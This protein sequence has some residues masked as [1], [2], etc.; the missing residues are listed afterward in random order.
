MA[1]LGEVKLHRLK[2][3]GLLAA[4]VGIVVAI[5]AMAAF[6][7]LAQRLTDARGNEE[8]ELSAQRSVGLAE[9][10]IASALKTLDGLSGRTLA[11]CRPNQR[12]ALRQAAFANPWVKE[13]AV[14]DAEGRMVCDSFA[15]AVGR[16]AIITSYHPKD[17]PGLTI[18][19]IWIGAKE[20]MVGVVRPAQGAVRLAAFIPAALFSPQVA[21]DG[22]RLEA[23]TR[24]TAPDGTVIVER[25]PKLP[26]S[27]LEDWFIAAR[28]SDRFGLKATVSLPRSA[29]QAETDSLRRS[30][31]SIGAAIILVILIL[32]F[33]LPRLARRDPVSEFERALANNE[34]VP[35]YQPIVDIRTGRLRGAEVLARWRKPDGS[36][37][38]PSSF[39]PLAESTQL[40][41]PLTRVLMR[42]VC[43]EAG[44]VIGARPEF[45]IG[46]NLTAAHFDDDTIIKDVREIFSNSPIA[47]KQVTLEVTERQPLEDLAAARRIIAGLQQ[48]GCSVAIDDVG[49]G[50]GGLSYMLKLGP[51]TIK[52]DKIFIDAMGS[53]HHST[54]ILETLVDLARYM[55]MDVVAEGVENFEQVMQLRELGILAAQGHVFCPPLPGSSFLALVEA[56][57]PLSRAMLPDADLENA[58]SVPLAPRGQAA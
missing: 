4:G 17:R 54:L 5:A 34:F 24:M 55:H 25:G 57:V 3:K 47:L 28:R 50:H 36:I 15:G 44:A 38:P 10:R 45:K 18:E 46:F 23:N 6:S 11:S 21:Q 48:L 52:I 20:P 30:A 42:R 58:G 1:S 33:I 39:I 26:N 13:I 56:T 22:S 27:G 19:V 51:D 49:T 41:I 9:S 43:E 40:I 31:I 37:V 29:L 2:L 53:E 12:E 14:V 16:R 8:V 32:A 7:L 35:Y